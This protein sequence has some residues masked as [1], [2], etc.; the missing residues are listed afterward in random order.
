[1]QDEITVRPLVDILS[2][3]LGESVV[4]SGEDYVLLRDKSVV[5]AVEVES[6]LAT[7]QKEIAVATI[8]KTKTDLSN[9]VQSLLDTKAQEFRYDNMMSARSYAGYTNPFQTEAQ[10]LAIW[11]ADCWVAA[12]Q[13]EAD[14]IAGNRTIPTA[15]EVQSEMPVY[16]GV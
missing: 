3:R 2:E 13:I 11:A 6:A 14:V 7:Q 5:A 10:S 16:V 12:G 9:A 1:M 15:E 8:E 4:M